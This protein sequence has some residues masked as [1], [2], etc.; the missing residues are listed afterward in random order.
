MVH[1]LR[2]E[3]V[4]TGLQLQ[5]QLGQ[6]VAEPCLVEILVIY[7]SL[8]LVDERRE[9]PQQFLVAA[10]GVEVEVE[11]VAVDDGACR[12]AVGEHVEHHVVGS[13]LLL[14]VGDG[15]VGEEALRLIEL[16]E[17]GGN[18]DLPANRYGHRLLHDVQPLEVDLREVGRDRGRTAVAPAYAEG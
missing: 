9:G 11:V 7:L 10:R 8:H 2:H 13:E 17:V 12:V 16:V 4:L 15:D 1:D 14:T 3:V 6:P 5:L 18:V